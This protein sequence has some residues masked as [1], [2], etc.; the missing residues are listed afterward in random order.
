MEHGAR[1]G[2]VGIG[3]NGIS[4]GQVPKPMIN[5]CQHETIRVIVAGELLGGRSP[6][7]PPICGRRG[8]R[9]D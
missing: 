8:R 9:S 1:P 5:P 4:G 3:P 7:L 2:L 6:K